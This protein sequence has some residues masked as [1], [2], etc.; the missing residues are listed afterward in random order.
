MLS[1]RKLAV[2]IAGVGLLAS[3]TTAA[4][5]ALSPFIDLQERGLTLVSD[6][7]GLFT[8]GGS[9]RDLTV[10]VGGTVRFALLYWAGR[11]RPCAES[12]PGTCTTG[13]EPFKDQQ[14]VFDGVSITGTQIGS[15]SQPVSAGGPILNIGYFAD[16]TSIVSAKGAGLQT[17]TFGDGNLASNLWRLDGVGLVVAYIDAANPNFYRVLVWDGLD[18][19]WGPDPTPGETRVTTPVTFNHGVNLSNRT[20]DLLLILG[21]GEPDRPDRIDISN[22]PSLFNSLDG[23]NG[24]EWDVDTVPISIPAGVGTTTVHAVSAPNPENPDSLLWEVAALRVQQ[25][26]FAPATCPLTVTQGPPTQVTVTVRDAQTGLAEILVTK[27]ENT[28][29]VVPP[30]TVGSTD[31]VVV[32]STKI[33]QSQRARVEIRVTDLA[34]NVALCDPILALMVRDHGGSAQDTHTDVPQIEDK[35]TFTNGS[36]GVKN[37]EVI[38]NGTKFKVT[39]LKDG[40]EQTLDIASAMHEGDNTVTIKANGPKNSWVNVMIWDGNGS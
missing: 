38:V 2:L 10:N 34:G 24:S 8:W 4:A 18:L 13:P 5:T 12:S 19:A 23:T 6:G 35:V 39:G 31:P 7:E 26:D 14:M 27:S 1:H 40:E 21:D 9:P 16:V 32:T 3:T 29:T 17:F 25:L 30:F 28:D 11:D 36:P 20:A 33:N 15:E 37:I 22:N